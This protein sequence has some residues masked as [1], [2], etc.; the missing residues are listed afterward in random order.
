MRFVTAHFALKEAVYKAARDEDQERMEFQDIEAGLTRRA[1]A[2]QRIWN[3]VSAAVA[4]SQY[5]SH[6]LV[7]RDPPWILA[8]ATRSELR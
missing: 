8:V 2:G 3:N 7:L 1:L 6:G 4:N 5:E